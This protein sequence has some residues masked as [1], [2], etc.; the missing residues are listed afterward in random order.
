MN[1]IILA[2]IVIVFIW[3]MV[4][5]TCVFGVAINSLYLSNKLIK[6]IEKEQNNKYE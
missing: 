4:L 5:I 6:E 2:L 1:N 3:F